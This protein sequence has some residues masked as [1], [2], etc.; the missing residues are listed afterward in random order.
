ME[1]GKNIANVVNKLVCDASSST[2]KLNNIAPNIASGAEI[3]VIR[4]II[5]TITVP[6]SIEQLIHYDLDQS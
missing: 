1:N 3:Q 4:P 6:E 2:K 5:Y